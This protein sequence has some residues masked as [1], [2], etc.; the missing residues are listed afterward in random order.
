VYHGSLFTVLKATAPAGIDARLQVASLRGVADLVISFSNA[1]RAAAWVLEIGLGC[2]A[3]AK[4]PQTQ[5]YAAT[6][7]EPGVYCCSVVV[8][9]GG[10]AEPASMAA[11]GAAVAIAWSRRVRMTWERA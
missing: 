3:F 11:G 1:P 7:N 10:G 4:L 8:K 6:R 9:A 2:D 5:D